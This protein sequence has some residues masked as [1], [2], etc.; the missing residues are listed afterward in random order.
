VS[1]ASVPGS[2]SD[3]FVRPIVALPLVSGAVVLAVGL[4][5]VWTD[6]AIL[7]SDQALLELRTRDVFT[8]NWPLLGPYSRFGWSHPGSAMFHLLALPYRLF[9]SSPASLRFGCVLVAAA[10]AAL[11]VWVLGRRST[12]SAVA[13]ATVWGLLVANGT[14]AVAEPWNPAFAVLPVTL[15]MCVLW[16]AACGDDVALGAAWIATLIAIETHVG[17]GA[18]VVPALLVASVLWWRNR[19]PG[20]LA[21]WP[22]AVGAVVVVPVLLDTL[23]NWPGNAWRIVRF[24]TSGDTPG[25]GVRRAVE[26]VARASS[27]EFAVRPRYDQF[28]GIIVPD[29]SLGWLPGALVVLLIAVAVAPPVD[30]RLRLAAALHL[31]VALGAVVGVASIRGD[32]FGYMLVFLPI[33]SAAGWVVVGTAV[34]AFVGVRSQAPSLRS[35][36]RHLGP[37]AIVV[38]AVLARHD[39]Y[40]DPHP[41]AAPL[42]ER[43]ADAIDDIDGPVIVITEIADP[44]LGI[45]I[46]GGLLDELD[47]RGVAVRT[48]PADAHYVGGSRTADPATTP[49]LVVTDAASRDGAELLATV[50]Q[51][52][53]TSRM[54]VI[55]LQASLASALET[56]GMPEWIGSLYNENVSAIPLDA[57]SDLAELSDLLEAGPQLNVFLVSVP[58]S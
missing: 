10:V 42:T 41:G 53:D 30:R 14:A 28:F 16:A 19:E 18:T 22:V 45:A 51:L 37:I 23:V 11:T 34:V 36:A 32:V 12:A 4:T 25:V 50:D 21:T 55:E 39:P 46:F 52:D 58:G 20:R 40:V 26:L 47:R 8:G 6:D 2:V 15:V 43:L 13:G 38:L 29:Q 1:E 33:Y 3:R 9:G 35:G 7:V 27:P 44:L 48:R 54:R 17:I 24:A 5:Q 31:C 56:A 49:T 57:G